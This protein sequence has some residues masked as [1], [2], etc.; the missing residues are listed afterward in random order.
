M[1]ARI[2]V[3]KQE[4]RKIQKELKEQED[5]SLSD[6]SDYIGAEFKNYLYKDFNMSPEVYER[7][8]DL[9]GKPINSQEVD[10]RNGVSYE[11]RI[12]SLDKSENM[13]EFTGVLLGD[14]NIRNF[15]R[16]ENQ[17]YITNYRVKVTLNE[18]EERIIRRVINLFSETT[19][20]N[21]SIYSSKNSKA[22]SLYVYSK[23]LVEELERLGLEPGDKVQNQ[24]NIPEWI[25]NNQKYAE[26]CLRGL[27][28]TDGA[29]Y[30]RGQE[31]SRVIQFKN[32]SKPLLHDFREICNKLDIKT[33]KGGY[34]T[35]QVA[36][37]DEVSRF[38]K[39]VNPIKSVE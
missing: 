23:D 38:I 32:A 16:K 37:Q 1:A 17:E 13:A 14:G 11:K 15:N 25:K 29:I 12:G 33:S 36:A 31:N 35:V 30:T 28:D 26:R 19:G 3:P 39:I 2:S 20:K 34:R 4:L 21:P 22:I 24:V 18:E 9:F 8:E 7:L 6:I 27:I 5:L 10:F